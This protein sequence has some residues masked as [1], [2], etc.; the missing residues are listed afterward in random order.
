[1]I[2][3]GTRDA[4][5]VEAPAEALAALVAEGA[6]PGGVALAST[7][8]RGTVAAA[9]G[10]MSV[11]AGADPVGIDTVYDLASVSKVFVSVAALTLVERGRISLDDAVAR[12]LPGVAP[13]TGALRVRHLLTHTG[14]LAT[15][16]E[17]HHVHRATA[18]LRRAIEAVRPSAAEP[19]GAVEYSSLGYLLLGW[20]V[21]A[22]S[23]AP[24]DRYLREAVLEPCGLRATT[25]APPARLRS[26]IAPTEVLPTW[27]GTIHGVVHDEKAR[28][29]GGV[30]GHAGLFAPAADVLRFGEALLDARHPVLGPCRRLLFDELTGGLDPRRSAAFVID[31]PV[32]AVWDARCL[33]HTGFTGTSLCL[34]PEAG[35]VAVLLTNRVHPTRRNRRIAG[36]RTRVHRAIRAG[37]GV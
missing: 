2:R 21:E 22:A 11:E 26:R 19:G 10:R 16:Q 1:M 24:L 23:G 4:S 30:T 12:H 28:I 27:G 31:D 3:A 18:P 34:V 37:L 20:I 14:G 35:V 15:G 8:G 7:G 9:A 36:A 17:L 32:F 25:F 6:F 29:L 5:G 13:E 33:S